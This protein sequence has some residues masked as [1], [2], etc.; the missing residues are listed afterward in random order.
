ML[1]VAEITF[2]IRRKDHPVSGGSEGGRPARNS[3]HLVAVAQ[4]MRT[5]C[6]GAKQKE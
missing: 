1:M 5:A 2:E 6:K 4:A 3:Q